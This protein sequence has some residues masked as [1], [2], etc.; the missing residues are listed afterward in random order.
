MS[1]NPIFYAPPLEA[2]PVQAALFIFCPLLILDKAA[3]C[4]HVLC[5]QS[6]FPEHVL[7]FLARLEIPQGQRL[8]FMLFMHDWDLLKGKK[9]P[10]D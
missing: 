7:I 3:A 10:V 5:C 6:C 4:A 9:S 1:Q 8:H 2:L